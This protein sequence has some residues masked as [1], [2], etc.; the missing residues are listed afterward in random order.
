MPFAPHEIENKKFI[1]GL[2]GYAKDEVELFLRAVAAD[3]RALAEEVRTHPASNGHLPVGHYAEVVETQEAGSDAA[4]QEREELERRRAA[5]AE[6]ERELRDRAQRLSVSERRV[7]LV[8]EREQAMAKRSVELDVRERALLALERRLH[9][10]AELIAARETA[11]AQAEKEPEPE[12]EPEPE[13][14]PE[15]EY[16]EVEL[17]ELERLV[18]VNRDEH[19]ELAE[20]WEFTLYHLREY[21][22][23]DGRVP[24]LF[25]G[26]IEEV[27]GPLLDR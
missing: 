27:F 26:M 9:E 24:L 10:R 15:G 1:V 4:R 25:D 19:P 20:S 5:V 14:I 12:P 16:C 8:A 22:D 3:Y 7:A 23:V 2:R 6:L 17:D 21:A 11:L 13:R 18:R